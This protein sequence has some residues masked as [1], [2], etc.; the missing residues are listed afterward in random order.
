[1]TSKAFRTASMSNVET[2]IPGTAMD[3]SPG[4]TSR[5]RFAPSVVTVAPLDTVKLEYHDPGGD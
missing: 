2:A 5:S 1:M 4:Q 3:M